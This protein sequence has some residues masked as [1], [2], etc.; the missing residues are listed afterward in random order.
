MT[1]DLQANQDELERRRRFI[2]A[3]ME[4]I[5]TGVISLSH[6]GTVQLV[7]GALKAIFPAGK[8]QPGVRLP[9]IL[10]HEQQPEFLRLLKRARRTG[11][12]DR[13]FEVRTPEGVR[14]FAVTAAALEATST[15]GMVVVIEDATELLHAQRATAWHE[16][17]RR[18]AHEL[19]NPLTP[20]ALSSERI[21]R[22]LEKTQVP[23][24]I[25]RIITE[26]CATIGREVESVKTLANEFS[27]FARFPAA[28]PSPADLNTV[29]A[30]GLAVFDGRLAGITIHREL[31]AGLPPVSLDR[32]QFKRVVVNLVDNAAEAM[33][34]APLKHLYVETQLTNDD[35][36]QLIIADTGCGITAEDKEKLFLPYFSTKQRGTGLGLAIVSHIVAEHAAHIRVEDNHPAGARFIIELPALAPAESETSPVEV[37]A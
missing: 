22:Q 32:E 4:S 26:C 37:P 31:A 10:P 3:V 16:V 18:I 33:A 28:H 19:K 6:D 34:H 29:V 5:P 21:V 17:A 2:E 9:E 25:K 15:S 24:E 1:Q 14:H 20:I 12:A 8:V 23:P 11:K 36:V 30:D 7:N 27:R 35:T 13:Q